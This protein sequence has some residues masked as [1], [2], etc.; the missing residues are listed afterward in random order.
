MGFSSLS[1]SFSLETLTWRMCLQNVTSFAFLLGFPCSSPQFILSIS[2]AASLA[3]H[4]K[5]RC[6]AVQEPLWG[7]RKRSWKS[8]PAI[9]LS[10]P[11]L[12]RQLRLSMK[13]GP[14]IR[15]LPRPVAHELCLAQTLL[16][17][18]ICDC[19]RTSICRT[20]D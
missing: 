4:V 6:K 14:E 17:Q 13:C 16:F 3:E 15:S 12:S 19:H 7:D 8:S 9:L 2:C 20:E 10:S 5:G 1:G 18:H 11:P